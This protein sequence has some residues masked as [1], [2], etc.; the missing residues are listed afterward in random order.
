[1]KIFVINE[2][3]CTRVKLYGMDVIKLFASY[4]VVFIH[5]LFYGQI[6]LAANAL[7]RFAVPLFFLVSGFYSYQ[8]PP[9]KIKK[10]IPHLLFLLIFSSILYTVYN[11]LMVMLKEGTPAVAEYFSR[12]GNIKN[13]IKLF[14]F[15]TP[16][17]TT[18]LWYLLAALYVYV[19][20][21][22]TTIWKFHEK[23][24][25][26]VSV[27]ALL[28]HIFL[29]EVLSIFHIEVPIPL[30]R[31]FLL[32]GIPFF[33]LGML[34]NKHQ[35]NLRTVPGFVLVISAI[36]GIVLT[37]LSRYFFGVHEVHV[38]SLFILFSL[39]TIFI[40]YPNLRYPHVLIAATSCSTYI[41]IFHPAISGVIRQVYKL[42]HI[43]VQASVAL[44]MIHPLIVCIFSTVAAYAME[45]LVK[46]FKKR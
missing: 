22:L 26:A 8:I 45:W 32:L 6:G 31:N 20:F 36:V 35:D 23:L 39:V 11:V 12:Y 37:L 25:F 33:G 15:N 9:D 30:L 43:D 2:G 10:R 34:A 17:H 4:M 29:G 40:K 27:L 3:T 1:M 19:V 38:G 13:L 42:I 24:L 7:A 44:Q 46:K 28:L 21:Y 14:V 16:V 18:H 5:V 41:Y